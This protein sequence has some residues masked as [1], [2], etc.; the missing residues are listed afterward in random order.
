M[1]AAPGMSANPSARLAA[2]LLALALAGCQTDA[3]SGGESTSGG[4]GGASSEATSDGTQGTSA[5][6]SSA[7]A[8]TAAE[9]LCGD[10][11]C[12][13]SEDCTT[14]A[15]DCGPCSGACGD[16]VCDGRES[17][18]VC[19]EDCGSCNAGTCTSCPTDCA[20]ERDEQCTDGVCLLDVPGTTYFVAPDGD[21]NNPGTFEQ[22]WRT[23]GKAFNAEGVGGGDIVYFRGGVYMKDP[24]EGEDGWYYPE[25][26]PGAGYGVTAQGTEDAWVTFAN[27]PGEEPILD[28]ADIVPTRNLHFAV[29]AN[30]SYVRF[31]G[32][33]VRNVF[34]VE[35]GLNGSSVECKGW[36][37][38]GTASFER[39]STY[40]V[41][42]ICFG[43]YGGDMSYKDCDAWSCSDIY[44]QPP[45]LPGNRGTG[46]ASIVIE[47]FDSNITYRTC[48]AWDCGD[49][50]FSSYNVGHVEID[51][52]WASFNGDLEGGGIGY[53]LGFSDDDRDEFT[54]NR[55]TVVNS[56]AVYNRQMGF[57]QNC[58]GRLG[59]PMELY[60]NVAYRNGYTN[61]DGAGLGFAFFDTA[62]PD[63]TE[64]LQVLRNNISYD[65]DDA[66]MFIAA[67]ALVTESHNTWTDDAGVTVTDEDFVALHDEAEARALMTAPRQPDG[68]LPDLQGFLQLRPDSDLVDAGV[69]VGLPYAG[70]APDLGP[71]ESE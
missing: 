3:T 52:C 27:Y 42:G 60:N 5:S 15:A 36:E 71:Y 1:S 34:S 31:I 9:P 20:C 12:D 24:S 16:G 38:A 7:G 26:Y 70:S 65:N 48:R 35:G 33:T 4:P 49:Q 58:N 66:D 21:D 13:P 44:A 68:S 57:D 53:K 46:F 43:T 23:W 10:G 55:R 63:A 69:D 56:L 11:L 64:L 25:R 22:P 8:S 2:S 51:S 18:E 47:N 62:S 14:C 61:F 54:T 37:V 19:P 50:G 40:N 41:H 67:T 45:Q 39:C 17:C 30:V 28:S 29:R 32:L 59:I 6:T